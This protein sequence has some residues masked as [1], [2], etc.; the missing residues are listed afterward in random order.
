MKGV[1][2]R[3]GPADRIEGKG[4]LGGM[5]R[6]DMLAALEKQYDD[7][8]EAEAEMATSDDLTDELEAFLRSQNDDD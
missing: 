7:L 2:V 4:H 8:V 1:G 6:S 5:G 3:C